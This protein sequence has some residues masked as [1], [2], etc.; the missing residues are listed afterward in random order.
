MKEFNRVFI[1]GVSRTGSKF[2]MQLLNSHK[3]IQIFPEILFKHP[4][5]TDFFSLI[6]KHID[7]PDEYE[8]LIDSLYSNNLK[9]SSF[10][11]LQRVDKQLF[12]KEIQKHKLNSPYQVLD[13]LLELIAK[14]LKIK[15]TGAKFP[16]HYSF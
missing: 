6:N 4:L 11:T 14:N 5:K 3:D 15:Y 9:E 12:L 1:I 2:Y 13:I 10:K 7:N 16:V 8:A